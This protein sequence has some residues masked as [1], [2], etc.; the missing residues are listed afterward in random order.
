MSCYHPL[1]AMKQV[2]L[3][4]GEF[5]K[6]VFLKDFEPAL[7][8]NIVEKRGRTLLETY[9]EI[10]CGTCTGCRMEYAEN[11][12]VRCV[13]EARQWKNNCVLTL[14]YDNEHLPKMPKIDITTGEIL[15][16]NVTLCKE[17]VQKFF[18]RLR[19][20]FKEKYNQDNIRFFMCGE[21]G[22]K[23]GR[24]HYHI[25]LFNCEIPDKKFFKYNNNGFKLYESKEVEKIWGMGDVKINDLSYEMCAYI[26]RYVL[27]KQKGTNAKA[28]Y[29]ARGQI[30]EF[31]NMSR[32]P[33][34]A[35][36]YFEE[37]KETIYETEEI[38]L[39]T[40][41]ALK[42]HKPSRYFDKKLE[43]LEEEKFKQ[44][45]TRRKIRAED[46]KRTLEHIIEYSI[47][48]YK[49]MLESSKNRQLKK[50]IRVY[51]KS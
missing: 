33:G 15:E 19:K 12:A 42:A 3:K 32:K 39:Q 40:K 24:P 26:A 38:W 1:K 5:I 36:K 35:Y 48:E 20:T 28:T 11:W 47:E 8:R 41:K 43:E 31:T 9:V 17:D 7:K 49:T 6:M 23:N 29:D 4:T 45:K 25:I 46:K 27:K 37:H 2:D 16:E 44:I 51:E 50:L 34:I 14:T 22:D 13:L 21:Y 10:P 30:P 18:K